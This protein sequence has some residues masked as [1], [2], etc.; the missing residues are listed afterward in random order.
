[1]EDIE[2]ILH[3]IIKNKTFLTWQPND[4]NDINEI[5][6]KLSSAERSNL[7]QNLN[8]FWNFSPHINYLF[9]L[10]II[11]DNTITQIVINEDTSTYLKRTFNN[12]TNI[13]LDDI[14]SR[15][16][17]TNLNTWRGIELFASTA[18]LIYI[19]HKSIY[20][21][22]LNST[23]STFG[24]YCLLRN[25]NFETDFGIIDSIT[26][27]QALVMYFYMTNYLKQQVLL[28][29]GKTKILLKNIFQLTNLVTKKDF[30]NICLKYPVRIKDSL[31]SFAKAIA[32][33]GD[34]I[35]V[36][37]CAMS[38]NYNVAYNLSTSSDWQL[39]AN[40]F[41][42]VLENHNSNFRKQLT[43]VLHNRRENEFVKTYITTSNFRDNQYLLNV[44]RTDFCFAEKIYLYDNLQ[45][46][47]CKID[48]LIIHLRQLNIRWFQ[49][50]L[51]WR[52]YFIFGII[53][54]AI[55]CEAIICRIEHN[56]CKEQLWR[57]MIDK[58]KLI[59]NLIYLNQSKLE[60]KYCKQTINLLSELNK[61]VMRMDNCSYFDNSLECT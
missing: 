37:H 29:A 35:I 33:Y 58:V 4:I 19:T 46:L 49:N 45:C 38:F 52:T 43:N 21:D 11:D 10:H 48:S 56:N 25:L 36:N 41:I 24:I 6:L 57:T 61:Y 22:L 27:P 60:R 20:I 17:E 54:F 55:C 12:N 51:C 53:E 32:L 13:L 28:S 8:N 44:I 47:N 7:N 1:M 3:D 31:P 23:D 18:R 59:N 16:F 42:Q 14:L 30:C 40:D 15:Y 9:L 39:I 26:N 5:F 34:E 50:S 2:C